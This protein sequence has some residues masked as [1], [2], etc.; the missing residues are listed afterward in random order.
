[1]TVLEIDLLD[2]T[3]NLLD[4]DKQLVENILQFAAE[5]L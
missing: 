5:Y 4:E 3:K 1:M 2:E